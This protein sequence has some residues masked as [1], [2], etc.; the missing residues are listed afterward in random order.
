MAG[1]ELGHAQRQFAIG[2]LA[3][4]E[5]LHVTGAV[6]RLEAERLAL[7]RL[8]DEHIGAVLVPVA[9]GFPEFS[10]QNLRRLDLDVSGGVQ[11]AAHIGFQHAPQHP[12]LGV[13][14]DHAP[15]LFLHVEELHGAAQLAVVA[16][17][18]LFDAQQ[19][20][21]QILLGR[22]GRA[23]DALKLGAAGIAAPI[24]ARQLGQLEGLAHE[25]GRRE[26]RP[27][28]QVGPF[29]LFVD[30]DRLALGQVADQFGLIGFA[31]RLEVGDGLV[32]VP[33]LTLQ[34]GAPV[35]DLGHLLLD[36]REVV[37]R[38]RLVAGEVVVEAVLDGRAD[39]HLSA[40]EEFLHRL[41]QH[42]GG[43]VT[44]GLQRLGIVAHQQAEVA[45]P[46]DDAVQVAL[47]AV[48]DDQGRLLG[49]RGRDGGGHVA[50]RRAG[51]ILTH[52]AV[53]EF[54]FDH[55]GRSFSDLAGG[56]GS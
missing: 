14:E 6:H 16:L 32:A 34:R 29:A 15:A 27:A 26:V 1:A 5:D 52:G 21:V 47:L 18:G 22:P 54:Q 13:P 55:D 25:L 31:E 17:L 23:V 40:G 4:I 3:L 48:P 37:G 51:R 20:G 8:A 38:E 11:T 9:R 44:D 19:I 36:L 28:A 49:Q 56:T 7:D 33:D 10:V 50:A 12:A 41:G 42:V 24:G 46:V 2:A 43:V 45:V 30:G 53:G 39:R 35:D